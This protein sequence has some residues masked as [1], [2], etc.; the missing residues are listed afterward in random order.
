MVTLVL[1]PHTEPDDL[2]PRLRGGLRL[3]KVA[4][5]GKAVQH[6][7]EDVEIAQLV[8]L[9]RPVFRPQAMRDKKGHALF[10]QAAVR[11]ETMARE[12]GQIVLVRARSDN[13]DRIR[14]DYEVPLTIQR[15]AILS[16][17][18]FGVGDDLDPRQARGRLHERRYGRA[19]AGVNANKTAQCPV[20]AHEWVGDWTDDP[21]A[22][23]A[24]A[25]VNSSSRKTMLGVP[26]GRHL[27]F[28]P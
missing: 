4:C 23:E 28:I 21:G 15:E 20:V 12:I 16:G 11:P 25:L 2:S 1:L 18:S 13:R 17:G 22:P 9:F 19:V 14:H 3:A 8:V 6:G 10:V 7:I 27:S 24:E 5:S 26:S